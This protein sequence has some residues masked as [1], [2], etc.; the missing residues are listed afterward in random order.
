M[1]SA[2]VIGPSR[3]AAAAIWSGFGGGSRRARLPV[4]D[5]YGFEVPD[6]PAAV[7]GALSEQTSAV[8]ISFREERFAMA[9]AEESVRPM[10]ALT[11]AREA[12]S[13]KAVTT[14]STSAL[15]LYA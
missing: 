13:A 3:V 2:L 8:V 11:E 5:D 9:I 6:G 1:P 4:P 10:P 15:P 7:G 14:A 12:A